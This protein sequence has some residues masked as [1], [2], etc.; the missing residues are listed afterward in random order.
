MK[1][2]ENLPS[3]STYEYDISLNPNKRVD[4]NFEF[5]KDLN[6]QNL[7]ILPNKMAFE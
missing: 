3:Q 4:F 7:N 2:G 6:G 1:I 5:H